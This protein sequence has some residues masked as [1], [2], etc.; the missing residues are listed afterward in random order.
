M[1][2]VFGARERLGTEG[3]DGGVMNL[4]PVVLV[5]SGML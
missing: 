4:T 2:V 3:V 5:A 1:A